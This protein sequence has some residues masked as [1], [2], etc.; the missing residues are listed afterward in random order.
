MKVQP[1]PSRLIACDTFSAVKAAGAALLILLLFVAGCGGESEEDAVKKTLTTYLTA[2]ANGDGSEACD[3]TT[4][5]QARAIFQDSLYRLPELRATSC[6]DALSKL[7]GSLGADEKETIEDAEVTNVEIDGSSATAELVGGT[8]VVDL[9][10]S[11]DGWLI[12]GG[13]DLGG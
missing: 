3:Q 9:S 10:K 5:E 1:S 4:G 13:L 7:S 12:S 8:E 11:G 2:L 6:A